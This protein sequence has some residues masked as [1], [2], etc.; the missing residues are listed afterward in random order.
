MIRRRIDLH[1]RPRLRFHLWPT[2][3]GLAGRVVVEHQ[4]R[5][6]SWYLSCDELGSKFH[7]RCGKLNGFD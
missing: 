1:L 3:L 2:C 7:H 4:A 6:G 5:Q